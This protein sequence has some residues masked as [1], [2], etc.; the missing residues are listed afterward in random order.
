MKNDV[1]VMHC[2]SIYPCPEDKVNLRMIPILKEAFGV[3]GYSGHEVGLA[4]TLAAVAMGA[5]VVER[6]FTLDRAM[7]GTDQ[8]ASVEPTGMRRLVK[9]IRAIE[10]AMGSDTKTI[11][12]EE[13]AQARKLRGSDDKISM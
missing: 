5:S 9:D 2:T 6:H 8:A 1:V 11:Y 4:P 10:A 3:V 13:K 7:W 12:P